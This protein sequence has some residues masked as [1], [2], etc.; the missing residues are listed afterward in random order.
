[1]SRRI[2]VG[3]LLSSLVIAAAVGFFNARAA[4]SV[5]AQ[6]EAPAPTLA[7]AS[8]A[9]VETGAADAMQEEAAAVT[10]DPN[11]GYQSQSFANGDGTAAGYGG[12]QGSGRRAGQSGQNSAAAGT[13]SDTSS[14]SVA[15][16]G[17]SQGGNGQGGNGQGG[18][19]QEGNGQGGNGQGGNGQGG[20]GRGAGGSSASPDCVSGS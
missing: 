1:M 16:G 11:P 14:G 8:P 19:G 5:D 12:G 18:N 2:I 15:P 6:V 4:R 20:G 17:N 7:Q 9:V 10:A 3:I 13:Y